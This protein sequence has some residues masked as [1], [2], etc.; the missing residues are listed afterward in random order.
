MSGVGREFNTS[1]YRDLATS[2]GNSSIPMGLNGSNGE[3]MSA[4]R[5]TKRT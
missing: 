4:V 1:I 3:P 2:G 5:R